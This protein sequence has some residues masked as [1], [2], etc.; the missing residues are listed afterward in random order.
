MNRK[1]II[2]AGVP[3][4][5]KSTIC[6]ELAIRGNYEHIEADTL[7]FAFQNSFPQTG[8]SHTEMW[9][10]KETSKPFSKFLS[11]WT[12]E[13]QKSSNCKKIDYKVAI[14][15][16]HI[17]PKD[18]VT[19]F[20]NQNCNIYFLAYPNITAEE[21]VKQIRQFDTIDDW[22]VTKSNDEL[23]TQIETYIEISKWIQEEC[24][25]YNLP[26]IDVSKNREEV[27]ENLVNEIIKNEK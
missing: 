21:K 11:N 25:K 2:I 16:Y 27:L 24:K 20:S 22:T 13:I 3:R 15:I 18:F 12:N 6:H 8:I 26:F 23:L 17:V 1:Q 5:G 10:L 19:Y 4:V 7:T 9:E 14:D